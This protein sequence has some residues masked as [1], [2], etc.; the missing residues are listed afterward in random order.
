M[1]RI[2][3]FTPA[4]SFSGS[5]VVERLQEIQIVAIA[6]LYIDDRWV[7]S[8]IGRTATRPTPNHPFARKRQPALPRG[9]VLPK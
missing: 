4:A 6:E 7:V 1:E 8:A 2:V 9:R 3:V 5:L